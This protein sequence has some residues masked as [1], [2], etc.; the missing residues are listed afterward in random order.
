M[1]WSYSA[2]TP[3]HFWS[4]DNPVKASE[5]GDDGQTKLAQIDRLLEQ[6]RHAR[7]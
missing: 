1:R 4:G 6:K 3:F 7:Y 2:S 5:F